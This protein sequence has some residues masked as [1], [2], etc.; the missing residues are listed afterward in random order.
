M[1]AEIKNVWSCT[2]TIPYDYA[3]MTRSLIHCR[4]KLAHLYIYIHALVLSILN[5]YMNISLALLERLTGSVTE[6]ADC[7]NYCDCQV[8]SAACQ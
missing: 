7:H 6:V 5:M 3:F 8:S 4:G 1:I 2:S